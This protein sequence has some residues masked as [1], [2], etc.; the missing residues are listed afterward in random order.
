M[1]LSLTGRAPLPLSKA[2]RFD[3]AL[4]GTPTAPLAER[5]GAWQP[6]LPSRYGLGLRSPVHALLADAEGVWAWAPD[7]AHA[8]ATR[9][10]SVPAWFEAHPG[11]DVR[12]WVAAQLTRSPDRPHAAAHDDEAALRSRARQE[13]IHRHGRVAAAWALATWKND[14]ARGVCALAGIDLNVMNRDA[15]R[16]GVRV[17]SV[18]PWW[19][20]AFLAAKRCVSALNQAEQGQVCVVEGAHVAWI[21]TTRG[22]LADVQQRALET[23]SVGALQTL[24]TEATVRRDGLGTATVVLGQGLADGASTGGL[25]A[26]VLGRLDGQQ[27]PLWLRPSAHEALH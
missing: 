22:L 19:Y 17:Q 12:L 4:A 16:H 27:P 11:C 15:S 7:D 8:A 24:I 20:H 21:T 18:V 1:F 9:H 23:A 2:L 5:R 13:F 10:A 3:T 6:P 14:A 25:N 26:L